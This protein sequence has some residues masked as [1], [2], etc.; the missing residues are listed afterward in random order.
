MTLAALRKSGLIAASLIAIGSLSVPA[1]AKDSLGV[2]Q[3][4]GA[5][6][7]GGNDPRC[8]A[9][10]KAEPSSMRREF[11]PYATIS[12]WPRRSLYGQVHFRLSRQIAA[13]GTIS[14]SVGDQRMQLVGGGAD[15]WAADPRMD[16]AIIA[17]MRSAKSMTVSARDSRGNR[18]SNSYNLDGAA[19]AM[20][21]ATIGCARNR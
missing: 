2:F 19:T 5:F 14:L 8:Y 9:I 7:D 11:Q 20:D 10:A 17:A 18:F 13:N 12:S 1:A 6:R 3:K 4:W 21:A 15:A 16:A